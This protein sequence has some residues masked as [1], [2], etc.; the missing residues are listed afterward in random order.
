QVVLREAEL[1]LVIEASAHP[2]GGAQELQQGGGERLLL[3]RPRG[4]HGAILSTLSKV[5]RLGSARWA[6]R[7]STCSRIRRA[8]TARY[9][10]APWWRPRPT[11]GSS[12]WRS[13]TMTRW[14]ASTRRWGLARRP[15]L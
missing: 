11:R 9:R 7:R 12:C 14:T 6:R 2:A 1:A 5:A 13:P 8:R 4:R 3:R 10:H 15:A